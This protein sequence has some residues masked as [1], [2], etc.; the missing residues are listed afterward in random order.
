MTVVLLLL[1]FNTAFR[2]NFVQKKVSSQS[3]LPAILRPQR[4]APSEPENQALI[5]EMIAEKL[6][7]WKVMKEEGLLQ[8]LTTST[9]DDETLAGFDAK[10]N[11]L[12]QSKGVA[13]LRVVEDDESRPVANPRVLKELE[14]KIVAAQKDEVNL[15]N[16]LLEIRDKGIAEECEELVMQIFEYL[17]KL[18]GKKIEAALK[19]CITWHDTCLLELEAEFWEAWIRKVATSQP[20][21]K[22]QVLEKLL[23]DA[24]LVR[25]EELWIAELLSDIRFQQ[26]N[27]QL[28]TTKLQELLSKLEGYTL[29]GVNDVVKALGL[30]GYQRDCF[31]IVERM[32]NS[33]SL[34]S[35]PDI[36]SFEFLVNSIIFPVVKEETAKNMKDLPAVN[37]SVPEVRFFSFFYCFFNNYNTILDYFARS[38]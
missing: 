13:A 2:Y 3:S 25:E 9:L 38:L 17:P 10:A 34:Q 20:L 28:L 16:I 5:D 33:R 24:E 11:K 18:A 19:L 31:T 29:E 4:A 23:L 35:R 14:A 37:M 30:A 12:L 1:Q 32:R 26:N 21:E 8:Q 6:K 7:Q 22:R 36:V 15:Y 27:P